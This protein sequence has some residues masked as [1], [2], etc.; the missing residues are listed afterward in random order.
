MRITRRI[1]FTMQR[2]EQLDA[3]TEDDP[4]FKVVLMKLIIDN[5]QELKQALAKAILDNDPTPFIKA[6]HKSKTTLVMLNIDELSKTAEELTKT[7]QAQD[8]SI[9][10]IDLC[11]DLIRNLADEIARA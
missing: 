11:D 1:E 4:D 9:V 10:F 5:L 6:C 8:K 7:I 3:Y 2:F